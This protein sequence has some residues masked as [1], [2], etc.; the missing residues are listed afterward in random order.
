ML[1]LLS[2]AKNLNFDPVDREVELTRPRLEKETG[3]LIKRTKQLSRSEIKRLMK[4]SEN[5]ADLNYDRFQALASGLSD[6]TAKPAAFAFNGDVYRGL[7]A[8]TLSDRALAYADKH[9]RILS[10]LYGLL[11]PSDLIHPY[12]LEMGTRLNTKR[13]SNLYE[14]WDKQIS[15]LINDDLKQAGGPVINLASNEYFSAVRK[16]ALKSDVLDIDFRELKDGNSKVISFYAKY[17]RG[18]LAR[19]I[20]DNEIS[21]TDALKEYT[22]DGYKFQKEMSTNARIVF[23]RP[24]PDPKT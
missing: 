1:I 17:A 20:I 18:A 21:T 2:P 4:L 5:L 3:L 6:E 15:H 24:K 11:R 22:G 14:F 13:G 9:L 12:R 19:W 7:Q 8:A 10:G 16:P 23:E